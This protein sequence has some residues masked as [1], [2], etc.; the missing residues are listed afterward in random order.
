VQEQFGSTLVRRIVLLG[1]PLTLTVLMIFHPS[2]YDDIKGE[3]VPIAVWW[4]VLHT[5]QFVLFAL[6]GAAL[7][8]L[9]DGLQGIA[10][11]LSRIAAAIFVM[12]YD[13][14]DAVAGISTGI[15]AYAAQEGELSERAA[16]AAIEAISH[17]SLKNGLFEIGEYAWVVAL[18][19]AG[20]ALYRAGA[21]R[22]PLVLLVVPAI[23]LKFFD[24]AFPYGSLAFGRSSWS[25]AGSRWGGEG[26]PW[27]RYPVA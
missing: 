19:T 24:H 7:W 20:F 27:P 16:V 14:G 22:I 5:L 18:A 4:T 8:M 6:M 2:P 23:F 26:R 11:T 25:L 10:V 13:A 12:L 1:T 17:D 9:T 3:L 21:P 15:L